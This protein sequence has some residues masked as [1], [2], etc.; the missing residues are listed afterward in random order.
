[1][2][3]TPDGDRFGCESVYPAARFAVMAKRC[4]GEI[5]VLLYHHHNKSFIM[6]DVFL[7]RL[8]NSL[9]GILA[10]SVRKKPPE[11]A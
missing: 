9:K 7:P 3:G 6:D 2:R 4:A 1:M 10:F 11:P 8:I 5:Q